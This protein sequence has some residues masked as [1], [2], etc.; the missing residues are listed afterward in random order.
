MGDM[1]FEDDALFAEKPFL[2]VKSIA[3]AGLPGAGSWG[4]RVGSSSGP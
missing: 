2:D 3:F 1:P 4:P